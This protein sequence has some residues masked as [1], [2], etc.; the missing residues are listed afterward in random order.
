[1][2]APVGV[3][4]L[5]LRAT[6][7]TGSSVT[8]D[9]W[10]L[11]ALELR[12]E[13]SEPYELQLDLATDDLG[14][15]V[16]GLV[17]GRCTLRLGREDFERAIHGVVLGADALGVAH[18]RLQLRLW[19]GPSLKLLEVPQRRRLFQEA[20]TL[21]IVE[22]LV[23]PVFERYGGTLDAARLA[24]VRLRRRDLC[25]QMDETDLAFVQRLLAEEGISF[26]FEQ[27]GPTETF[28]LMPR[29]AVLASATGDRLDDPRP[30][31]VRTHAPDELNE[32]S[33]QSLV[34]RSRMRPRSVETSQWNWKAS[35]PHVRRE[36]LDDLG[37][38]QESNP[39]AHWGEVVEHDP[40]RPVEEQTGAPLYDQTDREVEL[41][42]AR[43]RAHERRA[44]GTSNVVAMTAGAA[45]E[46]LE[47]PAADLDGRY[48]VVSAWHH[49][50]IG[51][52][53][54]AKAVGHTG[55]YRNRFS[56]V[57]LDAAYAPPQRPKP[58]APGPITA[59][60]VGPEPDVIH[61]DEHGRIQVR[62]H[63]DREFVGAPPQAWVRVAQTSAGPGFGTVFIPRVGM[64]V[65]LAFL[66]GDPDRPVCT[67]V[68]YNGLN[69]PPY[70]LPEHKTRSVI[71]TSSTEG[72]GFNELSFEDDAGRE[73]VHLR[74]E[75]NMRTLVKANRSENVGG[76]QRISVGKDHTVSIGGT[77]QRSVTEDDS[78]AVY[79]TRR[80]S[81]AGGRAVHVQCAT[82]GA[83]DALVVDG[84]H[85]TTA[86][87]AWQ[88]AVG[89]EVAIDA[90]PQRVSMEAPAEIELRVGE[91]KLVITP[92]AI[93]V[94]ADRLLLS[95]GGAE[96]EMRAWI[97]ARA[98]DAIALDAGSGGAKLE[99]GSG[100]LEATAARKAAIVCGLG[101]GIVLDGGIA[102]A[103][104][105]VTITTPGCAL[106]AS[107]GLSIT[108]AEVASH[109]TGIHTITGAQIH[110]N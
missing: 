29:S 83:D 78:L 46:L 47:H 9:D 3:T 41:L 43:A 52:Q 98:A 94:S 77:C 36:R 105:A 103:G 90:T 50:T 59:T 53:H 107:N 67:G 10:R 5:E 38:G 55:S 58:T 2:I 99:L 8:L 15:Y 34:H 30:L 110:L 45:F 39:M 85:R 65:V 84:A 12:E 31:R 69:T 21:E 74:A 101:S 109:A 82:E 88:L 26:A 95:S 14:L 19:I 92:D 18:R 4:E 64:E 35:E 100:E 6:D 96:V 33:V 108:A 61:T 32:E 13:L 97:S 16:P 86:R 87:D 37:R 68:V 11:R 76:S 91:S 62:M 66:G 80:V 48:V 60:V 81:V 1:M 104:D 71:R 75:R 89:S 25:V 106:A 73:E 42:A 63:W 40:Y 28:V 56:C 79:G 102:Q 22:Q 17:G 20:T 24:D 51:D 44:A 49:L 27:E 93:V 7:A 57:D 23:G 70:A 54:D 72:D